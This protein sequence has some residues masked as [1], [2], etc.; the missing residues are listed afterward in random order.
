[1]LLENLNIGDIPH[2]PQEAAEEIGLLY[3]NDNTPGMTRR[4]AGKGFSYYNADGKPVRD[5]QTLARIKSLII[6]PAWTDVWICPSKRGH[7]QAT[8]RDVKGRKQY[9][10]HADFRALRE[11]SKFGHMLE[12]AKA[13]PTIRCRVDEDMRKKSLSREKVLATVIHLLEATLI[14]VGNDSYAKDNKSFGLTTLRNSHVD[15]EGSEFRFRFKGKSGK[16]WNLKIRDRRIARIIRSC[17]ELPGQ[18]LFAYIDDEKKIRDVTSAD[19]NA[20]LK[21]ISGADITAK[22]FRTWA[23]TVLAALA[24]REFESF[25]SQTA[26]KKNIRHAIEQVAARLG[27]TPTIC[28]KCYVHPEILNCYMEGS[29]L[30]E[31]KEEIESELRNLDRLNPEETAVL[32]LLRMRLKEKLER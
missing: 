15:V 24:L 9:K 25:D 16:T 12:F 32:S 26:A 17:Q 21:E 19:V 27:N 30:F 6:P 4:L 10:Y 8:G 14:R 28:R 20:Y 11:T 13:L 1:M 22:D 5:E 29:L 23:G 18:E 3:V 7:I 2:D 31:I